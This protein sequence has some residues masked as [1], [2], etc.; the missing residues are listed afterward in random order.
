METDTGGSEN[1]AST[2]AIE[3][4]SK[5]QTVEELR[6]ELEMV[7]QELSKKDDDKKTNERFMMII[8]AQQRTIN[9]LTVKLDLLLKTQVNPRKTGRNRTDMTRFP[10]L[11]PPPKSQSETSRST[12]SDSNKQPVSNLSVTSSLLT[13][14]VSEHTTAQ[15]PRK[16]RVTPIVLLDTSRWRGVNHNF[17][18]LGI[19]FERAVAVDA[20]IR[21]IPNSE[22]DYRLFREEEVHHHTFLLP[23]ERSIHAVIRGVPARP[24]EMEIKEE[25]QQRGY[26][27]C[28]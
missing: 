1:G 23:S 10:P 27:P 5:E 7:L 12:P 8:E 17:I 2:M 11:R 28:T 13:S 14:Q 20:V 3:T 6:V 21:L 9:D 22:D 15:P 16:V 25:C 19:K 26:S 4:N 18:S 24:S